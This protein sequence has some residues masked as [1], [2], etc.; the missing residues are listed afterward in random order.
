MSYA[1]RHEHSIN[2]LKRHL[3]SIEKLIQSPDVRQADYA[4][5]DRLARRLFEAE[6]SN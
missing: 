2:S 1:T 5:R 6:R 4:I 3:K